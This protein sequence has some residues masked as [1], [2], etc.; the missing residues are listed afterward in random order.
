MKAFGLRDFL[1]AARRF[2]VIAVIAFWLGGFTFY[3]S[4]VIHTGHRVFGNRAETGFLTQQVTYWLNFSG[5]IALTVL[6]ANGLADWRHANR[7]IKSGLWV[8][9][10]IMV[11]ILAALYTLHPMIDRMLD[12]EAHRVV[13]RS[14]FYGMHKTYMN[15]STAQWAAGLLHV[16]LTLWIWRSPRATVDGSASASQTPPGGFEQGA[17]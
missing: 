5:V 11:A 13:D 2:L 14:Q 3:A 17:V 12:I 4:V 6:L 15:L 16:W 10:A 9:W 1:E 8:T 7:W